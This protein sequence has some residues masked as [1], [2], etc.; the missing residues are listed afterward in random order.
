MDRDSRICRLY[1]LAG[2][3]SLIAD[4]DDLAAF[5]GAQIAHNIRPPITVADN[6][7]PN[8]KIPP[9]MS[10]LVVEPEKIEMTVLH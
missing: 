10:R 1:A 6:T 2:R 7:K 4:P 5:Q 8:H 3:G 9:L